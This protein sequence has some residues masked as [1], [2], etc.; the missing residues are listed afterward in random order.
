MLKPD[1]FRKHSSRP[2]NIIDYFSRT[3]LFIVGAKLVR[4]SIAQAEDFYGPL[5]KIFETKLAG[6]VRNRLDHCFKSGLPFTVGTDELNQMT[7]ILRKRN[8]L[9]EFNR[10]IQYITGL[11][12]EEVPPGEYNKPGQETCLALLYYGVN[13]VAKIRDRLGAT[14]PQEADYGTVRREFGHD[15]LH[16]GAHASDAPDSAVRERKIVGLKGDEPS[17]LDEIIRYE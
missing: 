10:I 7:E 14:N 13:A 2:G 8:A 5:K 4:F 9:Y 16:N 11:S 6:L 1:T 17:E 15:I 3:G 12:P